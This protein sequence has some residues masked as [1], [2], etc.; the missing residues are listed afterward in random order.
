[1]PGKV[2]NPTL[3]CCRRALPHILLCYRGHARHAP[4]AC[5]RS[6]RP[7]RGALARVVAWCKYSCLHAR[8]T[9]FFWPLREVQAT[10]ERAPPPSPPCARR[11]GLRASTVFLFVCVDLITRNYIQNGRSMKCIL[12][13]ENAVVIKSTVAVARLRCQIQDV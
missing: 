2:C 7:M 12:N 11:F 10:F 3:S 13:V 8:T 5:G 4:S 1:M 9:A 6:A